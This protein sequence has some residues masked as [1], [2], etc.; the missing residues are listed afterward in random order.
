[1]EGLG[2]KQIVNSREYLKH[3]SK[4]ARLIEALDKS[5]SDLDDLATSL[6]GM[7]C[8]ADRVQTSPSQ[9]GRMEKY[10]C[11]KVDLRNKREMLMCGFEQYANQVGVM[12]QKLPPKES[13]LLYNRYI[14][15]MSWIRIGQQMHISREWAM[16][17]L[18]QKALEHLNDILIQNRA[19]DYYAD[20]IEDTK[21][22]EKL[23]EQHS[24]R[25]KAPQ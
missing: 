23:N 6:G 13:V 19:I 15:G 9:E 11:K 14:E 16:T 3:F 5:I 18:H 10:I 24:E 22:K 21:T 1:M 7:N 4:Y 8:D 20:Y 25:N 12:L 17:G 2:G